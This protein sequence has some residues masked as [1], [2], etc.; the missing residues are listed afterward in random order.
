MC[1]F[2]VCCD[3]QGIYRDSWGSFGVQD[4]EEVGDGASSVSKRDL[5]D[6]AR[7]M[8]M[9]IWELGSGALPVELLPFLKHSII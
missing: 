6:K 9:A 5:I 2:P 7:V 1:D 4:D 3:V 8:T